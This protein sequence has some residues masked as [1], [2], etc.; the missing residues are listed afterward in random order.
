MKR[1]ISIF[2]IMSLAA[3]FMLGSCDKI[4]ADEN[5]N[6]V[7]FAGATGE[8]VDGNGVSDHSQRVF[9]EKYTGVR[10]INCPVADGVIND[11]KAKYGNQLI[12][13]A[14]HDSGIFSRP[15]AGYPDL[16]T[17]DGDTWSKFFGISEYPSSLLN[18]A[19]SGKS[20]HIINPTNSMDGNIDALLAASPAVAIGISSQAMNNSLS[21][22]TNVEYLQNVSERLTLTLLLMEDSIVA[23]QS[24]PDGTTNEAY[25]HNHVL[26]DVITDVWGM[27]V[28]ADG[29]Q[30]TRRATTIVFSGIKGDWNLS[31]CHVVAFVSYKDSRVVLNAA[32]CEAE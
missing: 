20:A 27:D 32:E 18:R 21:I 23:K 5:G 7:T 14:I 12:P 2:S 6:Y 31:R 16:R 22:T 24:Q 17:D 4:E 26:R 10:C 3:T 28:D 13:V 25:V 19:E 8:W 30:G 9:L 11:A 15:Y 1:I 29:K